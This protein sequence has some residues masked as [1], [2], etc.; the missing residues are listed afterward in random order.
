[1]RFIVSLVMAATIGFAPVAWAADSATATAG[2]YP[3]ETVKSLREGCL[4]AKDVPADKRQSV[5]SCYTTAVQ[6]D[7]PYA[8]FAKVSETLKTKG[9]DGLDADSKAAMEKNIFDVNYCRIKNGAGST[10]E[11]R[12]TFP[13]A[14][15]P[16]LHNSCMAFKDIPDNKKSSFCTCYEGMIRTKITYSDWML[17]GLAIQLKGV[18]GLDSEEKGIFSIVRQV[19]V[20]CGGGF[21]V[22]N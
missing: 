15:V 20:G 16:A 6:A 5:C 14:G 19:R 9:P 11:E 3:A 2:K 22:T 13:D 10:A 1:M 12:A 21:A 4:N 8:T 18:Q 7:I 17:L